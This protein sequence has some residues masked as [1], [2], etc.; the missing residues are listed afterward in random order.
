MGDPKNQILKLCRGQ[1]L[2]AL[3]TVTEQGK[4]WVRYMM[5]AMDK[6]LV[7]RMCTSARSR[8]VEQL[9]KHP[10]VHLTCGVASLE[11]AD[12]Y[13]QIEAR[14]EVSTDKAERRGFWSEPLH[15]YF[16][17]PDDPDYAVLVIRPTRIELMGMT[18]GTPQIWT[19]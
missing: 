3:A 13:L 15:Q 6:N 1:V 19:A 5:G 8:K 2:Y 11:T 17:G 9:R 18:S 4:P 14:A 10:D 16:S 7:I 12:Q